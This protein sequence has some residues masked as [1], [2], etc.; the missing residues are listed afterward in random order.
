MNVTLIM[1]L[2]VFKCIYYCINRNTQSLFSFTGR[3][4]F[5]AEKSWFAKISSEDCNLAMLKEEFYPTNYAWVLQ[6]GAP[7]VQIFSDK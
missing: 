2:F 6:K 7:Y 4:A 5:I 1:Y 3:Y